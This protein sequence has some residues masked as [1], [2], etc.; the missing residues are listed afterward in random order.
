MI[1]PDN[2]KLLDRYLM[3][4]K[5]KGLT[6]NSIKAIKGDIN[7]F[8]RFIDDRHIKDIKHIDCDDFLMYCMNQRD[9]HDWALARKHTSI[10]MFF[11]ILI[12]KDYLEI[13][14]PMDKVDQIKVRKRQRGHLTTEE[15]QKVFDYLEENKIYRELALFSLLFSSGIRLSELYQLNKNS[16]NFE[17]KRFLVVGKGQKERICIFSEYAKKNI[18]KYLSTREDDLEPLF[19]SRENNRW[20]RRAIQTTIKNTIQ[21]AGIDKEMTTHHIR[22]SCA[23]HLLHNDIPL[24]KIQKILGHSSI[25]TTQIYA[26]NTMDDVQDLVE[27]VF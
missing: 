24:D 26:Y 9:N 18:I 17:T 20:S 23:M 25:A 4:C 11:K 22:H 1:H 15:I 12:K 10:N 2:Q 6:P 14:N 19:I 27:G 13:K 21:R 8:L 7:L 16:L 3:I 5:N